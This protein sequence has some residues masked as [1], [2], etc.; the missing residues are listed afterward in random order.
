MSLD[1]L[2]TCAANPIVQIALSA[3]CHVDIVGSNTANLRFSLLCLELSLPT[4]ALV[5]KFDMIVSAS[6]ELGLAPPADSVHFSSR[7]WSRVQDRS[8]SP[9]INGKSVFIIV[10]AAE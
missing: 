4:F 6:D 10:S 7:N 3:S 2:R 5:P 8:R 9:V 1:G